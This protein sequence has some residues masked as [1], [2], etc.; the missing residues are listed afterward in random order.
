MATQALTVDAAV[1]SGVT[2]VSSALATNVKALL[3]SGFAADSV[4]RFEATGAGS[5][6]VCDSTGARIGFVAGESAAVGSLRDTGIWTLR[7]I[8]SAPATLVAVGS[9]LTTTQTLANAM[10]T[11]LINAGLMKAE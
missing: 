11:I 8:P 6:E 3:A 10:R 9:D 4:V 1:A 7:E 5:I 2:Y